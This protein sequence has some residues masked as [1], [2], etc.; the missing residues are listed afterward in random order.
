MLKTVRSIPARTGTLV[1][2]LFER[3]DLETVAHDVT[4]AL[5]SGRPVVVVSSPGGFEQG[6]I[7]L[8]GE[9]ADEDS[10]GFMQ[11]YGS[12]IITVSLPTERLRA[13]QLPLMV[14]GGST[15]G[16][17]HFTI[18]VDAAEGVTTGISAADRTKTIRVLA[19]DTSVSSDLTRPGHVYPIRHRAQ[20]DG[21]A[22]PADIALELAQEA[23]LAACGVASA[24]LN[25]D[26]SIAGRR[27]S[28]TF[29]RDHDLMVVA[30]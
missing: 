15:L 1:Q 16:R 28:M 4:G 19:D 8:A 11:R 23:G 12:G 3:R 29:A 22:H 14:A 17:P 7:A 13:L 18:S 10:L 26:G 5:R 20:Q 9:T 24:L 6:A 25:D 27:Q 2:R 30:R 21:R